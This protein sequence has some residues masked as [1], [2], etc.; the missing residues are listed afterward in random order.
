M[1]EAAP[2]HPGSALARLSEALGSDA[3]RKGPPPV[4]RWNPA[5]CGE[6]DMRIAADG[7]WYYMGTPINR[8]ALVKLFSTVLRKDPERYVLVTPVER[9][10]IVVEDAPFLAVEMAVEGDGENR[11]IAFRT[12]VDDLVQIGPD[13]PLRF[14]QDEQGGVRPYVRVRGDLWALVTRTLALDLIAL[15]KERETDSGAVFGLWAG[16][17]F[18]PI[19]PVADLGAS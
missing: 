3:K 10:G 2:S 5:Y 8:P 17:A 14:E 11:Q 15:G 1:T 19:A 9:V 18:F 7:T 16:G 13:R 4:E 6:I 12:N